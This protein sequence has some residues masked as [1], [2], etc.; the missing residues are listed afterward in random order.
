MLTNVIGGCFISVSCRWQYKV[1]DFYVCISVSRN[2]AATCFSSF[3]AAL[4]QAFVDGYLT[5]DLSAKIKGI[6]EQ[7]NCD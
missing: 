4:K 2:T 7:E 1:I 5:T 3:Q 6:H